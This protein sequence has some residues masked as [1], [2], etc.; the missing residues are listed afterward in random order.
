MKVTAGL[1]K[2]RKITTISSKKLR[3]TSSKIRE[4]IF[5]ILINR[6][7]WNS[8]AHKAHL[9]DAFAGVGTISIEAFSRNLKE[10]TLIE[11][12]NK[13]FSELKKNLSKNIPKHRVTFYRK[14]FFD[15]D[16]KRNCYNIVYLDPPYLSDFVNVSIKKIL[17]EKALKKDGI[18]ISETIKSYKFNHELNEFINFSRTYGKSSITFFK[19]V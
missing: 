9:L 15:I 3:P 4:A 13:I 18:I 17:S 14:N 1:Y 8:W 2:T 16:L 7:D 6:Y 5:N 19:F 12:N 11:E 10:A